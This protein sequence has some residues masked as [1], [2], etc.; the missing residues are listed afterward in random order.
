MTTLRPYAGPDDLPALLD[1]LIECQAGGYVDMEFRSIELRIWLK[2]NVHRLSDW[3]ILVE[4]ERTILGFGLLYNGRTLGMLVAPSARGQLERRLV[5]WA[6]GQVHAQGLNRLGVL[7]RDDDARG[8]SLLR[9]LGFET[10][11]AELRMVRVL[12]RP[13][14]EPLVPKGI[15]IRPLATSDELDDWLALY[16]ATIGDRPHILDKWRAYRADTDYVNA[17][18]LVA[19]DAAGQLAGVCTCT[20]ARLEVQCLPIPEGR[21]EPIMVRADCRRL[22]LGTALVLSGLHALRRYGLHSA[23]LTTEAGNLRAHKL[24]E[25][26][27][28][29]TRYHGLWMERS[30]TPH[31]E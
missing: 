13:L 20:V 19:V 5:E 24:Y 21:T 2:N 12:D 23:A 18:D 1:L 30:E 8:L 4:G 3:T 14:P 31:T 6:A 17:L 22:G 11:E 15:S 7:C 26:H 29:R 10:V 27:G 28:Y 25:A 9:G 16:A